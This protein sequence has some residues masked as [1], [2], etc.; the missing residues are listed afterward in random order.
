MSTFLVTDKPS[1]AAGQT[2]LLQPT[3]FRSEKD[4]AVLGSKI[5]RQGPTSFK[6]TAGAAWSAR[7][8]RRAYRHCI[9]ISDNN[10]L[11]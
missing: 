9:Y 3:R 4:V 11:V 5:P 10:C 7:R 1:G 8:H 6:G 2:M